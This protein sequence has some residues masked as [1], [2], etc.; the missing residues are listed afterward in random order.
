MLGLVSLVLLAALVYFGMANTMLESLG[1]ADVHAFVFIGLLLGGSFV[2]LP[3]IPG[4]ADISLNFGGSLIPLVFAAYFLSRRES[5][6][7]LLWTLAAIAINTAV[8]YSTSQTVSFGLA[9]REIIS[10]IWFFSIISGV[11]GFLVTKSHRS[12]LVA[13]TLAIILADLIHLITVYNTNVPIF[14]AIGGEGIFDTVI[15]S[16][17]VT[18]FLSEIVGRNRTIIDSTSSN[19]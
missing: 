3:V 10:P 15:L 16:G 14:A 2:E 5:W 17:L 11:T 13:S 7:E 8:V 12:A 18:L 4:R 19:E 1:L 9:Q 6:G